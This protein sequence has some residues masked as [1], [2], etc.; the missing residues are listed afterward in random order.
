MDWRKFLIILSLALVAPSAF[1]ESGQGRTQLKG[2]DE[3]PAISGHLRDT[4]KK[5][6][7]KKITTAQRKEAAA[8]FAAARAAAGKK[9]TTLDTASPPK[10]KGGTN[11]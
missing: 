8:R 9:T 11:E 4:Q 6:H 7:I 10:M 1:C 5:Q 3:S 2:T